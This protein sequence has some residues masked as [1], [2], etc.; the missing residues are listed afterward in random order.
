MIQEEIKTYNDNLQK[1]VESILNSGIEAGK[2]QGISVSNNWK[3]Y[4][5]IDTENSSRV[6]R[7]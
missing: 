1:Q 2:E 3:L 6:K 7:R 5:Q 4:S